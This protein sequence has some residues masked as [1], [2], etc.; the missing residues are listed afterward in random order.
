MAFGK[1]AHTY[2][3]NASACCLRR[4]P[5][6]GWSIGDGG[7]CPKD[8]ALLAADSSDS[9]RP[10]PLPRQQG[11]WVPLLLC[12]MVGGRELPCLAEHGRRRRRSCRDEAAGAPVEGGLEVFGAARLPAAPR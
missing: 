4:N 9:C 5:S 12:R 11:T 7:R 3:Q 10:S 8:P 2:S 1:I 6:S